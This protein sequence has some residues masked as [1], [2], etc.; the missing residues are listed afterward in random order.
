MDSISRT[1]VTSWSVLK[2][3]CQFARSSQ[4]LIQFLQET[5]SLAYLGE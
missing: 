3:K 2:N 1:P 5:D 4:P